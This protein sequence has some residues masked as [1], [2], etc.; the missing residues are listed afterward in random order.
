MKMSRSNTPK[1]VVVWHS[2]LVVIDKVAIILEET[3]DHG[4]LMHLMLQSPTD[5]SITDVY[6]GF[7]DTVIISSI[8]KKE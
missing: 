6:P 1:R 3:Y 7:D 8:E 2:K 4:H 5:Q